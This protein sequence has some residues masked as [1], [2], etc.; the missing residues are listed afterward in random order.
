M[1]FNKTVLFVGAGF[2]KASDIKLTKEVEECFLNFSLNIVTPELLQNQITEILKKY[3]RDVFGWKGTGQYPAL[4]DHFT[5]LDLTAN[6]GHNIGEYTPKKLRAIRR[7]SIHRVFDIINS[8]FSDNI[9]VETFLKKMHIGKNN[10]I[11]TTNWDTSLERYLYDQSKN[12]PNYNYGIDNYYLTSGR[13]SSK[14]GIMICKLHGSANWNYCDSCRRIFE[15]E[16][17]TRKSALKNWTFIRQD[18]LETL[19][20]NIVD[21]D[22]DILRNNSNCYFCG[23]IL[24][25]R[26]A[27]FSYKKALSFFQFQSVWDKALSVLREADLWIFIGYSLPESDYEIRHLLKT[28]EMSDKNKSKK[29][30]LSIVGPDESAKTRYEK[31]FGSR[32]DVKPQYFDEWY[33][34]E[35]EKTN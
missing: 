22:E 33:K 26:V 27:T 32:V 20:V 11:I 29:K 3:Y 14:S 8:N 31:F 30:I 10:S 16:R 6:S 17:Q 18:D 25:A 24:S 35:F 21:L 23:V 5:T 19:G 1:K 12:K 28:A 4:D 13:L 15:G 34:E 2:S 9:R 7:L